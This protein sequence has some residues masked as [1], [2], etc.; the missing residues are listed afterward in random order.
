MLGGLWYFLDMSDA[1]DTVA[2]IRRAVTALIE[3][4]DDAVLPI[5]DALEQWVSQGPGE[6]C[7]LDRL[8]GVP[9]TWRADMRRHRQHAVLVDLAERYFPQ[10]HGRAAARAIA[11]AV[12]RYEGTGWPRDRRANRRPDGLVGCIF[13]ALSQ[14]PLPGHETLRRLFAA[15]RPHVD[16]AAAG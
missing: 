9:V 15:D 10:L 1:T 16:L 6:V 5:A 3:C 14:G 4:G 12:R 7:S 8:L 11:A 13:D 2:I